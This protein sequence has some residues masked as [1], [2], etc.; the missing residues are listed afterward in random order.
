M[1]G[2]TPERG[3]LGNLEY[4]ETLLS[5][6]DHG[7]V[8]QMHRWWQQR[9][10]YYAFE[11]KA[12]AKW[13]GEHGGPKRYMQH[14]S[15]YLPEAKREPLKSPMKVEPKC[16]SCGESFGSL[17]KRAKY[18][19]HRCAC[20]SKYTHQGCFMSKV[21]PICSVNVNVLEYDT[22]LYKIID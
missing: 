2:F 22:A 20:G 3:T 13:F 18:S 21:C 4:G 12:G 16:Y 19:V 11:T 8:K 1:L 17:S 15:A 14:V 7:S 5:E 9:A 6:S 10:T